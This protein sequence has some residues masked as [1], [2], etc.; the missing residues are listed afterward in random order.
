MTRRAGEDLV[1]TVTVIAGHGVAADVLCEMNPD[2][3]VN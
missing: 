3:E 1:W 2:P